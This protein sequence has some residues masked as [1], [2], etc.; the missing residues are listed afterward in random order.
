[1]V[2]TVFS[3]CPFPLKLLPCTT[4]NSLAPSSHLSPVGTGR[5]AVRSPSKAI[6]SSGLAS[7]IPNLPHTAQVLQTQP[8]WGPPHWPQSCLL[9]SFL[10]PRV[11]N[12]TLYLEGVQW[13]LSRDLFSQSPFLPRHTAGLCWARCHQDPRTFPTELLPSQSVPSLHHR[14]GLFLSRCR[15]L[16]LS[17]INFIMVL[18]A[19]SSCLSW[20]FWVAALTL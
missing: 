15:T 17:L 2:K 9:M 6:P 11:Q 13:V 19:C 20:C 12:W 10:P 5:A 18:S 7:P 14:Q 8:S 4:G 16:H 1:M 3:I